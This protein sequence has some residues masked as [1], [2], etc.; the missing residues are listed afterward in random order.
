MLEIQMAFDND[1]IASVQGTA[2]MVTT[3]VMLATAL[4]ASIHVWHIWG[5]FRRRQDDETESL[6]ACSFDSFGSQ[7]TTLVE[8]EL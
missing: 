7:L 3:V 6:S 5:Y 1:Q 4:H 8:Q 2:I